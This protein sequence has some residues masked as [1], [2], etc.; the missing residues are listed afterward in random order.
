MKIPNKS[1]ARVSMKALCAGKGKSI[2]KITM[3]F[4]DDKLLILPLGK[5][6]S[7]INLTPSSCL[8]P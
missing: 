1:F 7:K 2:F 4:S 5:G 8:V 6:S 3:Y